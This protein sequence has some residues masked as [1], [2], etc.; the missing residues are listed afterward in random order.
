VSTKYLLLIL[1]ERRR[2]QGSDALN[3]PS[4]QNHSP[5]NRPRVM[6]NLS[7]RSTLILNRVVAAGSEELATD[8]SLQTKLTSKETAVRDQDNHSFKPILQLG[9][10][11]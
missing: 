5:E 8:Q 1:E 7:R 3:I 11:F 6:E 2:R 4:A 10:E 9:T